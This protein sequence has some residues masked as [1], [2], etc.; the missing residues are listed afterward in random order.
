MD[1]AGYVY[2]S[3]VTTQARG[4]RS[5]RAGVMGG[6]ELLDTDVG[7]QAWV[8]CENRKGFSPLS[9]LSSPL[10]SSFKRTQ[11]SQRR[12]Q[13]KGKKDGIASDLERAKDS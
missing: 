10:K 5:L 9:H 1:E 13:N 11:S 3:I 7:K 12:E 4:A 8:L 6:C 2:V